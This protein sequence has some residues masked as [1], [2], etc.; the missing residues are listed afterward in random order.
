MLGTVLCVALVAA[1]PAAE[2][3]KP[4][5]RPAHVLR[6][7]VHDLLRRHATTEGSAQDAA[8]VDLVALYGELAT[9]QAFSERSQRQL[10]GLVRARL[11][12]AAT[13]LEKQ[14]DGTPPAA[15]LPAAQAGDSPA[16]LARFAQQ[17][18]NRPVP[19]ANAQAQQAPGNPFQP[20]APSSAGNGFTAATERNARQL[21][22][23][24]QTAIAPSTWD[25]NG[26]LGTIRYFAPKQVLV[27][28]QTGD[29]HDQI[30]AAL[31]GMRNAP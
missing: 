31:Q 20:P 29:I 23:I 4:Q 5:D 24:I 2:S 14:V 16:P 11:L 22:D 27:I 3:G 25:I 30:G 18:G 19:P 17:A 9:S 10:L 26:G 13:D 6:A 1:A 12:R 7:E 8:L 21:I 15:N 28:R